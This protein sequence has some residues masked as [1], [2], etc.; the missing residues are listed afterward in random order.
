MRESLKKWLK[1]HLLKIAQLAFILALALYILQDFNIS[2]FL[3]ALSTVNVGLLVYLVAFE[4]LYYLSHGIGYWA[5]THKRFRIKLQ[6]AIGGTMLAWLVD[7]LLPSAFIEGDVVRI[8]FLKQYGDWPSAISYNLFFRFL[9]NTTL[10]IFILVTSILAVNLSRVYMNYLLV[11]LVTILLALLSAALIGVFIFDSNRTQRFLLWLVSKLPAKNKEKLE[12]EIRKFVE[13]ISQTAKDFTPYSAHLWL[14]VL[15]L[16]GQWISGIL[17]PYFSLKSVGADVNLLLIAPGYTILT[18]FSLASIGVPFM[19][20]SVDVALITLYLLLGVPKERAVIAALIGR[21][22]TI[23][24]TLSLIYP[25]GVYYGKKLF[26]KK[27]IEE[28]KESINSIIKEYGITLPFFSQ[29]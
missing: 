21:G 18:I 20:G 28:M 16:M 11:Y 10:A 27:N 26:S 14:S 6:D 24:V 23:L 2:E 19:I 22:I 3:Q 7:L 29:Q 9:L 5:L 8:V 25:V 4:V 15:A 12:G 1:R 17:T 13:Y